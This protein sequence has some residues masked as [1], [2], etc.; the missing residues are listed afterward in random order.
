MVLTT[1]LTDRFKTIRKRKAEP[2]LQI[3]LTILRFRVKAKDKVQ[4][5]K[6]LVR[7]DGHD[8]RKVPSDSH[9]L[10]GMQR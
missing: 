6:G 3:L 1:G 4:K 9:E 2:G 8:S 10:G 5:E 7:L